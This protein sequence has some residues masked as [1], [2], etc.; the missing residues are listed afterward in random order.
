MRLCRTLS[1]CQSN[2]LPVPAFAFPPVPWPPPPL[3]SLFLLSPLQAQPLRGA[4][5]D[6]WGE[7]GHDEGVM[8]SVF[9]PSGGARVRHVCLYP[10]WRREQ[11]GAFLWQPPLRLIRARMTSRS[12]DAGGKGGGEPPNVSPVS[13]CVCVR[14]RWQQGN[15][16]QAGWSRLSATGEGESDSVPKPSQ[17]KG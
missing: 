3:P 17:G 6:S 2:Q 11:P 16:S 4:D 14:A 13:V 5:R 15:R 8:S 9:W 7:D 12:R 1:F 10:A